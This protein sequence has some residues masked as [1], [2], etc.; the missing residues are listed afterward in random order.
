[1]T[2]SQCVEFLRWALPRLGMRWQ[3]FRKVRRQVC[4]RLRRRLAALGVS[5]LAAY[6]GCLERHPEEWASLEELTHITIS[7]FNR[8][9]GL[10]AS[11]QQEVLPVLAAA[12]GRGLDDLEVWS[13]GCAS[14]EEP[15][16]LAI[17]WQLELAQRFPEVEI[18]IL[19]TDVDDTMLARARRGCYPPGSLKE[20]PERWRGAAFDERD[21]LYCLRDRFKEPVRIARHDIRS[22]PPGRFDLVMCRNL[23]FTY[24]DVD[25]QR[26]TAR[27]LASALRARGMLVLGA[28]EALPPDVCD[29]ERCGPSKPIYRRASPASH[30]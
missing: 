4:K 25:L 13:A 17:M 3:G 8:D 27:R 30:R 19:A 29:F 7:K 21:A 28:H 15:Y 12:I 26:A 10:F 6:Q 9:R 16:T 24:F 23:A 22:P 11:L 1:M 14:G 18:R 20:L 5:D 2:D